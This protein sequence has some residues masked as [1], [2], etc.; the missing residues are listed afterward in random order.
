MVGKKV[1]F[2]LVLIA[3]VYVIVYLHSSKMVM[4]DFHKSDH[5]EI[6]PSGYVTE[7]V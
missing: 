1:F 5:N 7:N 6:Y 4:N 2:I 3:T